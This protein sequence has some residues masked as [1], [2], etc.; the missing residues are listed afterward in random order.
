MENVFEGYRTEDTVL[1]NSGTLIGV[2]HRRKVKLNEGITIKALDW[3]GSWAGIYV[4]D[5][6]NPRNNVRFGPNL[7]GTQDELTES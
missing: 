6:L 3:R 2:F 1:F 5:P 7:S 4:E